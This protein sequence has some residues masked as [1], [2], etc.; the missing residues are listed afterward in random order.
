[1]KNKKGVSEIVGYVLLIVFT[2]ILAGI[3]F[4]WLKTYV[5]HEDINCPDGTS[6]MINS[7][8]CNQSKLTL[9]F[10]NNGKFFVGGYFIDAYYVNSKG[11]KI[12]VDLTK[13]STGSV[14]LSPLGIKFGG[15]ISGTSFRNSTTENNTLIV[16][17]HNSLK[18][19]DSETDTY[20]LV[21]IT[22][23]QS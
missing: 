14:T 19:G 2:L 13:N 17:A 7:Y 16:T 15:F 9:T 21:G 10:E 3:V 4:V 1:M 18:T 23:L 6:L 11:Q 5:P 8:T 22:N 12:L 20:N